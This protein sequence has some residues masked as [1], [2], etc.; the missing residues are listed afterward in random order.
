MRGEKEKK[1]IEIDYMMTRPWKLFT[2]LRFCANSRIS[3]FPQ[4]EIS[5]S[6]QRG[7]RSVREE[8]DEVLS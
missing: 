2:G 6:C 8:S 7:D 3:T 1:G 4:I 5:R